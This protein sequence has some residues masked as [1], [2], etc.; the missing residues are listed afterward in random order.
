MASESTIVKLSSAPQSPATTNPAEGVINSFIPELVQQI[1]FFTDEYHT[2]SLV[3]ASWNIHSLAACK[4]L[5]K[6]ELEKFIGLIASNLDPKT[7]SMAYRACSQVKEALRALMPQVTTHAQ[8]KRMVMI[9]KGYIAGVFR[10][11][12]AEQRQQLEHKIS[13]ELPN[14]H[15]VLF[16]LAN[17]TLEK[18]IHGK[19]FEKFYLIFHSFVPFK[20]EA[21]VGGLNFAAA[22]GENQMLRVMLVR[23]RLSSDEAED[24][25]DGAIA[26]NHLSSVKLLL[27]HASLSEDSRGYLVKNIARESKNLELLNLLLSDGSISEKHRG[28]A[29]LLSSRRNLNEFVRSLLDHG[30]ISDE[31]RGD[32]IQAA[33]KNNNVA[34]HDLLVLPDEGD[35]CSL[36]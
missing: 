24:A 18:S 32:A 26:G 13:G 23:E 2:T 31:K 14:R 7:S 10:K 8:A 19:K 30:P 9:T 17:V 34:L 25:I 5:T 36:M 27:D 1:L 22:R 16:R 11:L 35:E 28:K 3:C 33:V 4:S 6:E 29:V 20:K 21:F 12:A 15:R